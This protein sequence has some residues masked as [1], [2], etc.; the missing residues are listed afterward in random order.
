MPTTEQQLADSGETGA[1]VLGVEQ[2]AKKQ[3]LDSLEKLNRA[4][5]NDPLAAQN[6]YNIAGR[7]AD[8]QPTTLADIKAC[9]ADKACTAGMTVRVEAGMTGSP[10]VSAETAHAFQKTPPKNAIESMAKKIG[11]GKGLLA[12]PGNH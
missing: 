12:T 10:L 11:A 5:L 2:A 6:G 8:G 9:Q 1:V 3:G 4:A 7:L